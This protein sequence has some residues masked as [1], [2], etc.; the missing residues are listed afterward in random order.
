MSS[1]ND[2]LHIMNAGNLRPLADNQVTGTISRLTP[3][4]ATITIQI[5]NNRPVPESNEDF[6]GVIRLADIRL[7]ER[8]KIKMGDCFRLGDLVRAK[9]VRGFFIILLLIP[10]L[11][12]LRSSRSDRLR[13]SFYMKGL[14]ERHVSGC[15][16]IV[17]LLLTSYPS[18]FIIHHPLS[19]H[20]TR[21]RLVTWTLADARQLSL[22]DAR[23]YYLSTAANE[24]GV[25]WAKSEVGNVMVPISYQDMEDSITG[26][27]E[28]RKVAKPEDV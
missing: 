12:L 18:S 25:I 8:D 5:S 19:P 15:L 10:I 20:S 14:V 11:P 16:I 21:L 13:P 1:H 17:L 27:T 26:R 4:Q 24:L 6:S 9:V 3:Q 2:S 7:T 28:R 22:G 23:S